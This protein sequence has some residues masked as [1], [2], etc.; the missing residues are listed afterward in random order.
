MKALENVK[1]LDLTVALSG[2][3]C[4]Q[5]LAAQGAEVITIDPPGGGY[6]AKL[7]ATTPIDLQRMMNGSLFANKK[8]ITINLKSDKGRDLVLKLAEMADVVVSNFSPGTMDKLGLSYEEIHK[9]NPRAVYCVISGFGQNGPLKNRPAYDP[10]IQAMTGLMS[11]NGYADRDPMPLPGAIGDIAAAIYAAFG[12]MAALHARDTLTGEGQFV[13]VS[14]YDC[15]LSFLQN[16]IASSLFTGVAKER[17]DPYGLLAAPAGSYKTKDNKTVFTMIQTDKQFN[18]VMSLIGR[19][20]IVER[21]WSLKERRAN[22]A[23]VENVLAEWVKEHTQ[24]EV[25]T[26][27]LKSGIPVAPVLDL[28]DVANSPQTKAR[29]MITEIPDNW[30][31]TSGAIG[32]VPKLLVTPG[33]REWGLMDTG[34]FNEEVFTKVLGLTKEQIAQL[35]EEGC[36]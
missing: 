12:I 1:V 7:F 30:G 26:T 17:C 36:I 5:I 25:E 27:L 13:D 19:D 34:H 24:E 28:L 31:V 20:D 4:T 33:K 3:F 16:D 35:Q 10:I 29:E 6:Q 22:R 15:C 23:E 32:V 9:I 8:G 2:P 11:L 14:M 21:H 18:T